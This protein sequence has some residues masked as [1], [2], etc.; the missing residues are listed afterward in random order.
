MN[1]RNSENVWVLAAFLGVTGV[2]AAA[3]LAV[4]S[5]L[6]AEPVKRAGLQREE[7][8]LRMLNLPE[9]NN[10][11][12]WRKI[13]ETEFMAARKDGNIVGYAAKAV[14]SSGYGGKI[15]AL[16]GFDPD[17]KIL[18]VCITEHSETPG[19]GAKVCERK[20]QK[21]IFNLFAPQQKGLPPNA[22]LDQFN[23][24]NAASGGSWHLAK[25]GGTF[26]YITGATVTSRAVIEIVNAACREFAAAGAELK[27]EGAGK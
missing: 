10:T 20:V 12:R 3:I 2:L 16:I 19:L 22:V 7:Q 27:N 4:V 18:A 8:A 5:K 25:D 15:T 24:R 11:V 9:F 13:G 14:S 26:K 23:G 6:T 1:I 21:T 17:G